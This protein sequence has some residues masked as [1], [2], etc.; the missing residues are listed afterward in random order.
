MGYLLF[1]FFFDRFTFDGAAR[2][3]R[4]A[5]PPS[6]FVARDEPVR[7][8][9]ERDALS[10]DFFAVFYG[11]FFAA[12]DVAVPLV[13]SAPPPASSRIWSICPRGASSLRSRPVTLMGPSLSEYIVLV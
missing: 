11:S 12:E 7:D 10:V 4:A 3:G 1:L 2:L 6:R 8:A 5:P 13:R 9:E